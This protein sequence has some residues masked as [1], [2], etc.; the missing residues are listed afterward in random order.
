MLTHRSTV[1]TSVQTATPHSNTKA[2]VQQAQNR[3]VKEQL[4]PCKQEWT[5]P[6]HKSNK[7]PC[8]SRPVSPKSSKLQQ[9]CIGFTKWEECHPALKHLE[10]F[11]YQPNIFSGHNQNL[12]W[13]IAFS[14][15]KSFHLLH[16]IFI[17]FVWKR[18]RLSRNSWDQTIHSRVL[19]CAAK[20]LLCFSSLR[21]K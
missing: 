9:I 14:L 6:L 1:Q 12:A 11:N 13:K 16:L 17:T 2:V 19:I 5:I 4:I 8:L 21:C 20:L 10:D 15:V 3:A 18:L 7:Y